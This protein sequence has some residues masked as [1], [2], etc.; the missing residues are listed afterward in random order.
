ML[1]YV[2]G[3]ARRYKYRPPLFWMFSQLEK[4]SNHIV[5]RAVSATQKCTET[6]GQVDGD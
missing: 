3:R 5:S 6:G 2:Y 4:D 1:R